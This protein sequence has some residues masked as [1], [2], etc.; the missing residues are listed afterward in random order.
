EFYLRSLSDRSFRKHEHRRKNRRGVDYDLQHR[1]FGSYAKSY[2]YYS[3]QLQFGWQM[4]DA[5]HNMNTFARE[6][7]DG[8]ANSN[9]TSI[10]LSKVTREIAARDQMMAAQ[11]EPSKLVRTGTALSQFMLLTSPSYW[12][13][14]A[15]QP[16]MVTLPWLSARYGTAEA[17]AALTRAQTLIAHPILSHM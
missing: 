11:T 1:A 17:T 12:L 14:N 13:I 7:A 6:V 15:T 5:L 16:Y 3:A 8:E 9:L 2:S 4:A 10:E